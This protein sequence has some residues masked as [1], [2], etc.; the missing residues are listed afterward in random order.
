MKYTKSDALE[1]SISPKLKVYE[2][3]NPPYQ[4]PIDAAVAFL[5]GE[6]GPKKNKGFTELLYVIEGHVKIILE[7]IEFHLN[8]EDVFIIPENKEHSLF[9]ESAKIFISCTPPFHPNNVEMSNTAD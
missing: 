1:K 5:N 7:G 4:F 3:C 6:F 9:G 2:Y 8:V